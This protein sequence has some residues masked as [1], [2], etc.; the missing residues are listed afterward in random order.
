MSFF[1]ISR[2]QC[3]LIL[4]IHWFL[5]YCSIC[6]AFSSIYLNYNNMNQ[7]CNITIIISIKQDQEKRSFNIK[8]ILVF[9]MKKSS[10]WIRSITVKELRRLLVISLYIIHDISLQNQ[11]SH[12]MF[13]AMW[14]LN[15]GTKRQKSLHVPSA[16][17][18]KMH[19]SLHIWC[20]QVWMTAQTAH[21]NLLLLWSSKGTC[22][23]HTI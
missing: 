13:L 6:L 16:S 9:I 12:F 18:W 22:N 3:Y 8:I 23:T 15:I 17:S 20:M 2:I 4:F 1:K 19:T 21:Q 14:P 7:L 5:L 10:R 11:G